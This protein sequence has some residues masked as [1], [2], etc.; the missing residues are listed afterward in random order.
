MKMI[1]Y[2]CTHGYLRCDPFSW[3]RDFTTYF[4]MIYGLLLGEYLINY[5]LINFSHTC[6][7]AGENV[8]KTQYVRNGI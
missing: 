1:F 7:L 5:D 2:A 4:P 3:K 8:Y 6:T